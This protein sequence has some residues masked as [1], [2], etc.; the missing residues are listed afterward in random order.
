MGSGPAFTEDV[1]TLQRFSETVKAGKHAEATVFLNDVNLNFDEA[2]K[3]VETR[4]LIYRIENQDGVETGPKPAASGMHGTKPN[5][6][7]KPASLPRTM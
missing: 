4:H 1:P 5:Q 6:I 2:G 7:L 3:L